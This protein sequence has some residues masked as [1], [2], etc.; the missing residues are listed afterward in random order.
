MA[1]SLSALRPE[2]D[3]TNSSLL[4]GILSRRS[5]HPKHLV[6]PGPDNSGIQL[7]ADSANTATDH[8]GLRPWRLLAITGDT[9]NALAEVFANIKQQKK[10]DISLA[11]LERE[12][13][14][15]RAVPVLI[16]VITRLVA[17]HPIVPT[18]EQYACVGAAIQNMLL[19]AEGLGFGA[20]MVSGQKVGDPQLASA[21]GLDTDEAVFGFICLGTARADAPIRPR[22][23]NPDAVT[24][25][26]GNSP[27]KRPDH[28]RASEN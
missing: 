15:A 9:R 27:S 14:R 13:D 24:Y 2:I 17:Q 6:E 20:K 4:N 11:E 10:P 12:R 3:C 18:M 22:V 23:A 26:V 1:I 19:C 21:F 5:V 25:W 8:C 28:I 7:I 16:A